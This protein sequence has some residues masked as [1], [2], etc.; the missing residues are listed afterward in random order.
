MTEFVPP[1][2]RDATAAVRGFVYQ[3]DLTIAR[4]LA[5]GADGHLELECGEDIDHIAQTLEAQATVRTLEQVKARRKPITLRS[6][7]ALEAI[8]N[9]A[10][11]CETNP[12]LNLRF[13]FT[14]TATI[15][16]ERRHPR[17]D[18]PHGI[19][20][21]EQARVA[22]EAPPK[23][24]LAVLREIVRSAGRPRDLPSE[25]WAAL[26]ARL[27]NHAR[28]SDVVSRFEWSTG[29]PPP[30]RLSETV[31]QDLLVAGF[32]TTAD[33]AT[34]L[35]EQLFLR[36]FRLL[37]RDGRKILSAPDLQ[38]ELRRDGLDATDR[39]ALT[40]L[41]RKLLGFDVR[42]DALEQQLQ[43]VGQVVA[44]IAQR[45]GMPTSSLVS[46]AD[47]E[48]A[49]P[50]MVEHMSRRPRTVETILATRGGAGWI[51]IYGPVGIGK[52]HL[53]QLVL[54]SF[55]K[56]FAW[57]RFTDLPIS[58]GVMRLRLG[59][60][61]AFRGL[62]IVP[63]SLSLDALAQAL[64]RGS[65]VVADDLPRISVG[66]A[67]ANA[68]VAFSRLLEGK[69]SLLVTTSCYET[70]RGVREVASIATVQAPPF[71]DEECAEILRS[72][73]GE[74]I[75]RAATTVSSLNAVARG[76]ATLLAAMANSLRERSWRFDDETLTALISGSYA[77][78]TH[79]ETLSALFRLTADAR[80]R[81]MLHRVQLAGY[82]VDLTDARALG[83]VPPAIDDVDARVNALRGVWLQP[84][85][86]D[87]LELSPMLAVLPK[88][89]LNPDV[90]RKCHRVLAQSLRR[91]PLDEHTAVSVVTHYVQA[92]DFD[93]AGMSLALVLTRLVD[94]RE[95]PAAGLLLDLWWSSP[96]PAAMSRGMQL[97]V[98]D[99]QARAGPRYARDTSHIEME[100]D[101]IAPNV[102]GVDGWSLVLVAVRRFRQ[103]FKAKPDEAAK[104]MRAGFDAL[105]NL[106][107]RRVYV[108]AVPDLLPLIWTIVPD[109]TSRA[110]IRAWLG[111]IEHLS[112]VERC[113]EGD[114]GE[115]ARTA[116]HLV[117]NGCWVNESMKPVEER[118]FAE[119]YDD[120]KE[121]ARRAGAMGFTYLEA[122]ALRGVITIL[123][124]FAG[125][126]EEGRAVA[127]EFL[128]RPVDQHC[129]TLI[130][131]VVGRQ[132]FHARRFAEA[133][134]VLGLVIETGSPQESHVRG[135]AA[136][137][138]SRAAALLSPPDDATALRFAERAVEI[139]D[140]SSDEVSEVE[141]VRSRGE[142]A[143]AL[144]LHQQSDR[145]CAVL[146]EAGDAIAQNRHDG[147]WWKE[148]M[149]GVGQITMIALASARLRGNRKR[150]VQ[151]PTP[152]R[153]YFLSNDNLHKFW[154]PD[155]PALFAF[156]MWEA[157]TAIQNDEAANR[158]L[159]RFLDAK[160]V[161]DGSLTASIGILVLP[162]L[163][164]SG[165]DDALVRAIDVARQFGMTVRPEGTEVDFGSPEGPLGVALL[166]PIVIWLAEVAILDPAYASTTAVILAQRLRTLTAIERS[167]GGWERGAQLLERT[168]VARASHS[169][170]F[171]SAAAEPGIL[172]D[173]AYLLCATSEDAPPRDAAS[174]QSQ[175][176]ARLWTGS[177]AALQ[178]VTTR[179]LVSYWT[180]TF[181][182]SRFLFASPRLVEQELAA[183]VALPMRERARRVLDTVTAGLGVHRH[184]SFT[185]WLAGDG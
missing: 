22:P 93:A 133:L 113:W 114:A 128:A 56:A 152:Q 160:L 105:S 78:V 96:L 109:V 101:R 15:G 54:V 181:H 42:V 172:R 142:L 83:L 12:D 87:R 108:D 62:G 137:Y 28:W 53:A 7:D 81:E 123:C 89:Q 104:W 25:P 33:A 21:W 153:G 183:A 13:L 47:P 32:V 125:K 124:E 65:V 49:P 150:A 57:L 6:D 70:P 50:P 111:L 69:G 185:R 74:E 97:F 138:A 75:A 59:L 149:V 103:L 180:T 44:V 118:R 95:A 94:A 31:V 14:T 67:L 127:D 134:A 119:R 140:C 23:E 84:V 64:P 58:Q 85:G 141:G 43:A 169:D 184:E 167:A 182:R 130:R 145:A 115:R 132:L 144:V 5:I 151:A 156:Q 41:R 1:R 92:E 99:A 100:I 80:T 45:L 147:Q 30:D 2:D 24:A 16:R 3:V 17:A 179:W 162:H 163:V 117:T 18:L 131:D 136:N 82:S 176:I 175:L 10:H 79:E 166:V 161:S 143:I 4:W 55:G 51:A 34:R 164:G 40:E 86:Q 88:D 68:L 29:Q 139:A 27:A 116:C 63:T 112:P 72:Y 106:D 91:R 120:L 48:V 174:I 135:L 90:R 52:T 129:V 76:H 66:D 168:F 171:A 157:S 35:Y 165:R 73:G 71:T 148:L 102:D 177:V 8:A 60:A 159:N 146:L 46:D 98:R 61:T 9:A 38:V 158:W 11:H 178:T 20:L 77:S 37:A 36:V 121:I 155:F 122:C 107:L 39:A 170:L 173:C 126:F 154:R 19:V 26:E 110:H